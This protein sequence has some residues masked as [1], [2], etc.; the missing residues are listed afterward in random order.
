M[1]WGGGKQL[2]EQLWFPCAMVSLAAADHPQPQSNLSPLLL[3]QMPHGPVTHHMCAGDSGGPVFD[4][5]NVLVG[6]HNAGKCHNNV[7]G[8][9]LSSYLPVAA[10][11]DW[12]KATANTKW[13]L[14]LTAYLGAVLL[15]LLAFFSNVFPS[16]PVAFPMK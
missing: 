3:I 11:L 14:S 2:H 4:S 9:T 8:P 5:N 12:I 6:I 1:H 16:N 13:G 10:V 15:W 7:S